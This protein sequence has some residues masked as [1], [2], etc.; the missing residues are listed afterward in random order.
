ML[1]W[2]LAGTERFHLGVLSGRAVWA[3][4]LGVLSGPA[5]WACRLGVLSIRRLRFAPAVPS[6]NSARSERSG[7]VE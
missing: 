5:V 2:F 7:R 4:S 1:R 6:N 3:C